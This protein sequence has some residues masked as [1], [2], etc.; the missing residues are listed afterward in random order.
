MKEQFRSVFTALIT[1]MR[2]DIIDERAFINL[3]ELQVKSGVAG[4]VPCGSTGEAATLTE[5][6]YK[7]VVELCV[8]TVNKRKPVMVGA[9]SNSTARS[10]QM[11]Q[12]AEKVGADAV[13]IVAPYYNKPTQEGIYQHFKKISESTSLPIFIYNIPGRCAVDIH[14]DTIVRLAELKNIVG[15]KDS[16]GDLERPL[17]LASRLNKE[18]YQF[19]GDDEIA[20]AFNAQGGVGCIS[21]ASNIVPELCVKLQEHWAK[22]EIAA[23]QKLDNKL[24][25]LYS[26]LFC[27]TNPIPIKYAASLI[28]LCSPEVRLPLTELSDASK[29]IVQLAV[30]KIFK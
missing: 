4:F 25:C 7:R 6:E 15:L 5:D 14:N 3:I 9:G 10:I 26:S 12:Y 19:A 16:T 1:P 24:M 23:A 17:N 29:K 20:L 21:V 11:V 30:E 27:E 13:I 28:G 18:F 8:K 22:G 2:N